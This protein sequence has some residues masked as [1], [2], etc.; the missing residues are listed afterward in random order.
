MSPKRAGHV[1]PGLLF[2]TWG[3]YWAQASFRRH[4]SS[5][6]SNKPYSSKSWYPCNL[7]GRWLFCLE[8]FLKCLAAPIGLSIELYFDSHDGF[9]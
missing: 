3:L 1:I 9:R 8:P 4:I 6:H 5:Q 2:L 7:A